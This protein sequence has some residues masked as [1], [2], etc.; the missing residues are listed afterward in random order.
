M[1]QGERTDIEHSANLP[2]VISQSQAAKMLNVSERTLRTIRDIKQ[3]RPTLIDEIVEGK[4]SAGKAYQDI[5]GKEQL[6]RIKQL[7]QAKAK[8][9]A[10]EVIPD[11]ILADPPWRYDFSETDTR[12]IENQYPTA[13]LEEIK[14]HCPNTAEN[15]ILFLWATAPKLIEAIDVIAAWGFTYKTNTV[16]DKMKIGMG[17]WTR[18]Q[19]EHLL[20]ATKGRVEPPLP[21]QRVAS[22]FQERRGKHSKKPECVYRW[23]EQTFP[24]LTKLEMYAR[25]K[26]NGWYASGNEVE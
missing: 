18:G 9:P 23:I 13:T 12:K 25:T 19:H 5:K 20:I 22:I 24:H 17:Y 6:E 21:A 16:W 8:A 7:A 11:L 4:L 15:C 3:K 2:K 1:R 26:R 10:E 14:S